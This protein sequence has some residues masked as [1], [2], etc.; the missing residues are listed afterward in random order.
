MLDL[1]EIKLI[2]ID[3]ILDNSI[4]LCT[5]TET[6]LP[7]LDSVT[8]PSLSI[9]GYVFKSFPRQSLRHGG[10]TGIL[11]RDSSRCS[12]LDSKENRSFEYSEWSVK[13]TCGT[14][15][16]II[17]YRPPYLQLHQVSSSVFFDE[18]STL[19]GNTVMFR[20]FAYFW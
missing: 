20:T 14:L 17:V 3:H 5:F 1:S 12:F 13:F 6:W 19:L 4:D 15:R 10:G 8:I 11:F 2:I 16:V 9:D 18:F 7:N